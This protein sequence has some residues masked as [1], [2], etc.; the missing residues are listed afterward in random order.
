M[1]VTSPR[2][3]EGYFLRDDRAS[4]GKVMEA[5]TYT[6]GHCQAIVMI[7]PLR[8]RERPF[9]KKCDHRLCDTCGAVQAA[10][11]GECKNMNH[12]IEEMREQAARAPQYQPLIIATR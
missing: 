12:L 6:C 9:C 7:D 4:G 10:T 3:Y 5:A 1:L 11:G 2:K 8:T